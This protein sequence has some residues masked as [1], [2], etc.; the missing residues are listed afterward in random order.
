MEFDSPILFFKSFDY[1][2]GGDTYKRF[3]ESW[4]RLA[5][6]ALSLALETDDGLDIKN[7][8]VFPDSHL[9]FERSSGTYKV[10]FDKRFFDMVK[11]PLN[12]DVMRFFK[13][14]SQMW[15]MASLIQ[16]YGFVAYEKKELVKVNWLRFLGELGSVDSDGY[17]LKHNHK[18]Q[19]EKFCDAFPEYKIDC[20]KD[21]IV[22]YPPLKLI[23]PKKLVNRQNAIQNPLPAMLDF[24]EPKR[25]RG[26][27]PKSDWYA[28]Y[29]SPDFPELRQC[30]YELYQRELSRLGNAKQAIESTRSWCDRQ[31]HEFEIASAAERKAIQEGL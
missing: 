31:L 19:I 30:C 26:R 13:S 14:S 9:P 17:R 2:V 24:L 11:Y 5:H 15:D 28:K 21:F 27:P 29:N 10:E 22:F 25:G 23:V 6:V 8:Q 18:S 3:K 16:F 20:Q 12:L 1:R 7:V 4:I